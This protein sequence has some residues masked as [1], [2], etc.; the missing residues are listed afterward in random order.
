MKIN[1][2]VVSQN[3]TS[4]YQK[5]EINK[6]W[7]A[8]QLKKP[9]SV[10]EES[11]KIQL[12][13]TEDAAETDFSYQLSDKD[14]MKLRML[15]LFISRISGKEFKFKGI[16]NLEGKRER[17]KLSQNE[18]RDFN[19]HFMIGASSTY[20][21]EERMTFN[22][23]GLV[24]TDDGRRIDFDYNLSM[25]RSYYENTTSIFEMGKMIDPLVL[26][27]NGKG[28]DFLPEKVTFD[29]NMDGILE[30]ISQL[31]NGSGYLALDKNNNGKIDNGSELFGPETQDGFGEL[32]A[33]DEDSNGWIDENDAIFKALK[34]WEIDTKG[35]THLI[36]LSDGDVGAI[37]VGG[38]S[39]QYQLKDGSAAIRESSVYLKESGEAQVIHMVDLSI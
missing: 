27:L 34:I 8:L 17:T 18:S 22:S 11:D 20:F 35:Q 39:S 37:Y 29:I 31:A 30:E 6:T 28:I 9:D 25:A 4:S 14:R 7:M 1:N 26:D 36:S 5:I 38:V 24:K 10:E 23:V 12:S 32:Q 2:Y 33:Y 19:W 13:D 21:E 3:A 16:L 15:E